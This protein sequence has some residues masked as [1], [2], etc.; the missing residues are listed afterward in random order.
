MMF[1]ILPV[2]DPPA[3]MDASLWC[4]LILWTNVEVTEL[5]PEL[6]LAR[7]MELTPA[8]ITRN[9]HTFPTLSEC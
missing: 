9:I 6:T 2:S 3:K 4:W 7:M 1:L 5:L 8:Q